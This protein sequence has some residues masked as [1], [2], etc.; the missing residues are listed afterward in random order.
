MAT[1]YDV[2][3]E[4]GVSMATVSRVINDSQSVRHRTRQKVLD[5]M[6]ELGY[7]PSQ[8]AQSLATRRT[9]SIG[10][11]VSELSGPFY[12]PMMAGIEHELKQSKKQLFITAGKSDAAQEQAGI[13]SL[14]GR[15]CDALILHVESVSDDYLIQL[16]KGRT[17]F[18]LLN[19]YIEQIADNCIVLDNFHGG[20]IGTRYLLEQGH[21]EITYISGPLW[22]T[23]VSQ[24]LGGHKKALKEFGIEFDETSLFEGDFREESGM[25]GLQHFIKSGIPM[26]AVVC[27]NDEIAAG[28]MAMSRKANIKVPEQLSILGFDD[29]I[30]AYYLHPKLTTIKYPIEE[31]ARMAAH[32]VLQNVYQQ[33][34]EVNNT[35]VPTLIKRDSCSECST[36]GDKAP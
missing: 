24:R 23:D 8:I 32:W 21:R 10:L 15:N 12:G 18:V 34:A 36:Q 28:A 11:M 33:E 22:K 25:T 4:A 20:Y 13:E 31:M 14:L 2:C 5:A 16:S 27:A 9:N 26:T 7:Q 29:I 6:N 17:P 19:R 30:L 35:F 3:K 1:I